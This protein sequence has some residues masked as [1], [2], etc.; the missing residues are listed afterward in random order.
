MASNSRVVLKITFVLQI[1]E[2]YVTH[3]PFTCRA[4][5]GACAGGVNL[6]GEGELL[7]IF[8]AL[9][10][11]MCG[12]SSPLILLA[13]V[14][15]AALS[16]LKNT[17]SSFAVEMTDSLCA[18]EIAARMFLLFAEAPSSSTAVPGQRWD[19]PETSASKTDAEDLASST[20]Y[21]NFYYTHTP[22]VGLAGRGKVVTGGVRENCNVN[23]RAPV[24]Q[25]FVNLRESWTSCVIL[26]CCHERRAPVLQPFDKR[27]RASWVSSMIH[28][29][30]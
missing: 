1:N 4:K 25:E 29:D 13:R 30:E 7:C 6:E 2:R 27:P 24:K 9:Q 10:D 18:V 20:R 15:C 8:P 3:R 28:F 26:Y 12:I 22:L 19:V 5:L 21:D 14:S 23:L 16:T 17:F 11:M